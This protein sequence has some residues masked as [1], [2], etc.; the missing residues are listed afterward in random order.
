MAVTNRQIIDYLLANPNLS[1]AQIVSTMEQFKIS[2]AQMASAVNIPEGQI[3]A[4]VGATLPPNQA[5]LLGDTYVQA[6]NQITG[7]GEDQQVGALENV[8]TYKESEN[9]PGGNIQ[10]YS[11][12]GEFQ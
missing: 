2:P 7:S 12:T 6:V 10:H 9:K 3:A 5:V 11:P 8:I 4:R 1:D